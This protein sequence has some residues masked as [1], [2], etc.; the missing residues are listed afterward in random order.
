[1]SKTIVSICTLLML[2]SC[3]PASEKVVNAIL[4]SILEPV[5]VEVNPGTDLGEVLI[6]EEATKIEVI[7]RNNSSE[8]ITS[9]NYEFDSSLNLVSFEPDNKGIISFPGYGGTCSTTLN[10]GKRCSILLNIITRKQGVFTIPGK[11]TYINLVDSQE[12]DLTFTFTAGDPAALSFTNNKTTYN[13]GILEISDFTE[14]ED[15]YEV[16]NIGGLTAR[17]LE[18]SMSGDAGF[19]KAFNL[20]SSNC[21]TSLKIGE[22]CTVAVKYNSVNNASIPDDQEEE[23]YAATLGFKYKRDPI[24]N[25]GY[26]NGYYSLT[27][28]RIEA[29]FKSSLSEIDFGE[30]ITGNQAS[31]TIKFSNRGFNKGTV[32][33]ISIKN[34]NDANKVFSCVLGSNPIN[35]KIL[36]CSHAGTPTVLADFP[37][38]IEDLSSCFSKEINYLGGNFPGSSDCLFKITY[39]PSINYNVGNKNL[40]QHKFNNALLSITYDSFW[41]NIQNSLV[42]KND[43]YTIYNTFKVKGHIEVDRVTFKARTYATG[44]GLDKPI[45]LDTV[46]SS[47]FSADFG[48]LALVNDDTIFDSVN[49]VLKNVGESQVDFRSM[50]DQQNLLQVYATDLNK[51]NARNVN[52]F[53]R[54]LDIDDTCVTFISPG[55][56]CSIT[57]NL[58][59]LKQPSAEADIAQ[60][61]D[62]FTGTPAPDSQ[63]GRAKRFIYSYSDSGIYKDDGTLLPERNVNIDLSALMVKKARLKITASNSTMGSIV[64]GNTKDL[65]FTVKNIGT[66]KAVDVSYASTVGN[67][68]SADTEENYTK[69]SDNCTSASANDLAENA[70]CQI[71]ARFEN[72]D[73]RKNDR[74][75][76]DDFRE[77][78]QNIFNFESGNFIL[79][80]NYGDGDCPLVP[81]TLCTKSVDDI[82]VNLGE[83]INII[84]PATPYEFTNP[85]Q[86]TFGGISGFPASILYVPKAVIDSTDNTLDFIRPPR[87]YTTRNFALA[88]SGNPLLSDSI[89]KTVICTVAAAVTSDE[90]NRK[91]IFRDE[92]LC[93]NFKS[94]FH[95]NDTIPSQNYHIVHL[96]RFDKTHSWSGVIG[97]NSASADKFSD[98]NMVEENG[99]TQGLNPSAFVSL[100]KHIKITR[101]NSNA[102]TETVGVPFSITNMNNRSLYLEINVDFNNDAPL[103]AANFS[104]RCFKITYKSESLSELPN[105]R[106]LNFCLSAEFGDQT[107]KFAVNALEH[108]TNWNAGT[109]QFDYVPGNQE[110]V[111]LVKAN[112][113]ADA[114]LLRLESVMGR[115]VA[116]NPATANNDLKKITLTNNSGAVI[117][118]F[119]LLFVKITATDVGDPVLGSELT[120]L[121]LK[122]Q[123]NNCG[124]SLGIGAQCDFEIK[125]T[126][127]SYYTKNDWGLMISAVD[128]NNHFQHF[129]KLSLIGASANKA[130]WVGRNLET[131]T[132]KDFSVP[133]AE[134]R[135]ANFYRISLNDYAPQGVGHYMVG[136]NSNNTF[137]LDITNLSNNLISFLRQSPAPVFVGGWATI[138]TQGAIKAEAMPGCFYGDIGSGNPANAGFGLSTSAPNKCYLRLTFNPEIKYISGTCA[139]AGTTNLAG[140]SKNIGGKLDSI[141]SDNFI[142][143]DY[144]SYKRKTYD[145]IFFYFQGDVEAP[146]INLSESYNPV[147]DTRLTVLNASSKAQVTLPLPVINNTES[148]VFG[149]FN[150]ADID[151]FTVLYTKSASL[152]VLKTVNIFNSTTYSGS[153]ITAIQVPKSATNVTVTNLD[154]N[155][156]YF[157]KV[158]IRV[159]SPGIKTTWPTYYYSD[160]TG[161]RVHSIITPLDQNYFYLSEY[162][163]F[164]DRRLRNSAP[165]SFS[166][167]KTSCNNS[168]LSASNFSAPAQR[169]Y[170]RLISHQE[171]DKIRTGVVP[172]VFQTNS[173]SYNL[174][175]QPHWINDTLVNISNTTLRK[176]DGTTQ[177]GGF[178]NYD[179]TQSG[180]FEP[181]LGLGYLK[182]CTNTSCQNLALMMGLFDESPEISYYVPDSNSFALAFPR[183]AT[184]VKC[185]FN[186]SLG[187]NDLNCK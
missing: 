187:I 45:G 17:N 89:G 3:K 68:F 50:K 148:S 94:V 91:Y 73:E 103:G 72:L 119:K 144:W 29:K 154:R 116:S 42:T 120:T 133:T 115:V 104:I 10:P 105:A 137:T 53:Y 43:L 140:A 81:D 129:I 153:G 1:M 38:I 82:D 143:L 181:G 102:V 7:I 126:P 111:N 145:S 108:E 106:W 169:M 171:F 184:N 47:F 14:K 36:Q 178:P 71:V 152:N 97:L 37:Y 121:G 164:V 90:F 52:E 35:P 127:D 21:P 139:N 88:L 122:I 11:I 157:F 168:Y 59:L 79:D 124:A 138:K 141:C 74:I 30:V 13:M 69:L 155:T 96:G 150:P 75:N 149:E 179:A 77:Y 166:A 109:S 48:R 117:D 128:D 93:Q 182:T 134:L 4:G 158:L 142:S 76:F 85:A 175:Y 130:I 39:Q 62:I 84:T 22:K 177:V 151:G 180:D 57:F 67:N 66:G 156:A 114:P 162:S 9:L 31:K 123:N 99:V 173:V 101:L 41:K 125:F 147:L 113:L 159:R 8:K 49:I 132:I 2:T 12:K 110:N 65:T 55:S 172:S 40:D 51:A 92:E 163:S 112:S 6:S 27:S 32:K 78:N 160:Y 146:R 131:S 5:S 16:K 183:C 23:M 28:T 174:G 186:F 19:G 61:F 44:T 25:F 80:L 70:T 63:I 118:E 95:T 58:R 170:S 185:P 64:T 86:L 135:A 161:S 18:I 136:R 100:K 176:Y 60:M 165:M 87:L 33:E 26:L 98:L 54:S 107:P 24:G 56:T 83:V 34:P 167:A 20:V 46:E 15:V